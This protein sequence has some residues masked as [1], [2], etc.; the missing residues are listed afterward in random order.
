MKFDIGTVQVK[1][2]GEFDFGIYRSDIS[3]T[4]IKPK[5]YCRNFLEKFPKI[6]IFS[7]NNLMLELKFRFSICIH[8]F[9]S[10]S[11]CT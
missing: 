9:S 10:G 6:G 11:I 5:S 3:S 8:V 7:N 4:Y 1:F 2:S